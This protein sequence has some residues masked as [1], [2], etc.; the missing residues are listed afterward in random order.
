MFLRGMNEGRNDGKQDPDGREAGSYQPQSIEA[1]RHKIGTA[2]IWP[3]TW[4]NGGSGE[5]KTAYKADGFTD[6]S[7]GKETRPKNVAVYFY[8]KIN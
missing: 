4:A 3:R 1:H 7:G 6:P 8:I 5:P 2:G